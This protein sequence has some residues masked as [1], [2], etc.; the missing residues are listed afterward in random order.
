EGRLQPDGL[1]LA[2][3]PLGR[4][5]D[6][7]EEELPLL[8]R[9]PQ[10]GRDV[11]ALEPRRLGIDEE[12]Q[13]QAERAVLLALA[14]DDENRLRVLDA[15]DEGLGPAQQVGAVAGAGRG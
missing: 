12:Q 13:W 15:G 14:G 6:V 5:L 1:R 7:V 11:L 9:R 8:L 10:R 4:H 3:Q 2:D